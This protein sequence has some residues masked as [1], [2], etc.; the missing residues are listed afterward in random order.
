M[1]PDFA[2]VCMHLKIQK[3]CLFMFLRLVNNY[4]FHESF[5]SLWA[6]CCHVSQ[7]HLE[8]VHRGSW[9]EGA[10]QS[11][12]V[13]PCVYATN[14]YDG[15][16]FIYTYLYCMCTYTICVFFC[17]EMTVVLHKAPCVWRRFSAARKQQPRRSWKS[18][19]RCFRR[20]TGLAKLGEG[21]LFWWDD[22]IPSLFIQLHISWLV[23]WGEGYPPWVGATSGANSA[24][25]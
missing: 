10:K 7:E 5:D 8:K 15:D 12:H 6:I 24:W 20:S 11:P 16:L 21:S 2:W 4:V 9:A 19:R 17:K 14:K 3:H 22:G 25:W 23:P 1:L 13:E 18:A